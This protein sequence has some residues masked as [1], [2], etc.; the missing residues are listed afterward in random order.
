MPKGS[1]IKKGMRPGG[2]SKGTPNKV[3]VQRVETARVE[4]ERARGRDVKLGKDVLE[5]FMMLFAGMAA[6]HQPL[7]AGMPPPPGRTP[8]E[9]KFLTYA[10]LTVDTAKALADFQSP[11]FKA[12][13]VAMQPGAGGDQKPPEDFLRS[14]NIIHLKDP[15]AIARVYQRMVKS[16]R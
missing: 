14:E 2:R 4:L 3:T 5:E 11:K 7:P 12:I 9:T 8:D 16:V 10:R 6:A 1:N 15:T 13:M